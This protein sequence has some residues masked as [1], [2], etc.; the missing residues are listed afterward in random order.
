MGKQKD[1][2]GYEAGIYKNGKLK[3]VLP[4]DAAVSYIHEKNKKAKAIKPK[5]QCTE[6]QL[7]NLARGREVREAN[8]RKALGIKPSKKKPDNSTKQ[9][10]KDKNSSL[11]RDDKVKTKRK[12]EKKRIQKERDEKR[13][14]YRDERSYA[15]SDSDGRGV[16]DSDPPSD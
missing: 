10:L 7:A 5:R 9:K 2:L 15:S 8:R 3:R 6:A 14:K 13:G 4:F 11:Y 16:D 12:S 1:A